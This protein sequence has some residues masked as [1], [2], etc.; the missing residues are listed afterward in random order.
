MKRKYIV[1]LIILWSLAFAGF[2]RKSTE[3]EVDIVT[4]F[5]NTD[6]LSTE[7]RVEGVAYLGNAYFS[8][9]A[10]KDML[11]S[12]AEGLG[13]K[14]VYEF[15]IT[16]E[17]G[18]ITVKYI[19]SSKSAITEL[20]FVTV[21]NKKDE[22][23]SRQYIMVDIDILNSPES[24]AWYREKLD[25]I[26]VNMGFESDIT[27]TLRGNVSGNLTLS[28]KDSITDSIIES[29]GGEVTAQKKEKDIYTVYAYSDKISDYVVNGDSKTN[30]NVAISYD[31]I[32]DETNIYMATPIM[33]EDY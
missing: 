11:A 3:K 8:E 30:I 20:K 5:S 31:E 29:I 26:Y 25:D 18:I 33:V 15:G 23:V 7:S 14:N 21:A 1:I 12:I 19:K 32:M 22:L 24:A 28:E 9:D 13:I 6:F 10:K 17:N 16:E 4:A 27:L 2:I